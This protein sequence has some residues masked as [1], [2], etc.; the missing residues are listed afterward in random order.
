MFSSILSD[1]RELHPVELLAELLSYWYKF[2]S[3][4]SDY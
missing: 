3:Y 2:I 4:V 1:G